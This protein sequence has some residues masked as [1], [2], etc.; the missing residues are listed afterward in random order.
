VSLLPYA[1]IT[2]RGFFMGNDAAV[3]ERGKHMRILLLGLVAIAA[4]VA[5]LMP[6]ASAYPCRIITTA[7]CLAGVNEEVQLLQ[8]KHALLQTQVCSLYLD[9]VALRQSVQMPIITPEPRAC[10]DPI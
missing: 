6:H 7:E 1:V 8:A 3:T 10:K 4:G 5:T 9:L 2:S